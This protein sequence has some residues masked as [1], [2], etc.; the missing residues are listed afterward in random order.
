MVSSWKIG[1]HKIGKA[2]T[3]I[4]SFEK[5]RRICFLLILNGV[6]LF[7][8]NEKK[9]DTPSWIVIVFG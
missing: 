5:P 6:C 2:K 9:I 3:K 8:P 4:R 1:S 7:Q